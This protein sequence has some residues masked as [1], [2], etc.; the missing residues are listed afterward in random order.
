MLAAHRSHHQRMRD[1]EEEDTVLLCQITC[2]A[3]FVRTAKVLFRGALLRLILL[4]L[5]VSQVMPVPGSRD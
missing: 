5:C 3:E 4:A 1:D 2:W